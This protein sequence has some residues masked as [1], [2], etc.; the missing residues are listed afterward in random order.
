MGR[1]LSRPNRNGWCR[2]LLLALVLNSL[3]GTGCYY[4]HLAEGQW[5]L[6]WRR[7]PLREAATASPIPPPLV[8]RLR[9]VPQVLEFASELGLDTGNQYTR[10]VP[11]DGDRIITTVVATRPGEI[12][13]A[14]FEFP[15]LGTLPYKGFFDRESAETE[16]GTLRA[17]GLDVCVVPV[18]AYSSLGWITD[19]VTGPMLR[20]ARSD[21]EFVE[22]LFHELVHATAYWSDDP[23]FSESIASFIGEEATIRFAARQEGLS[24]SGAT[25]FPVREWARVRDDREVAAGLLRFRRQLGAL[26][27]QTDSHDRTARRTQL[28]EKARRELAALPLAVRD[29]DAL[30]R[31]VRLNDACL[32]LRGTYAGDSPQHA[33][34]LDRL[35]GDLPA[36]VSRML[37]VARTENPRQRFFEP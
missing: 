13:P 21:G 26:Y 35:H 8:E 9:L 22:T 30:A 15:I 20:S 17:D 18:A 16:A 31:G 32:A 33:G 23:G 36:F 27:E 4:T 5:T 2:T 28:E 12:E 25:L 11:W 3:T 1:I 10:F 34:V 7:V 24:S 6:W 19:P 37:D 29:A 14:G